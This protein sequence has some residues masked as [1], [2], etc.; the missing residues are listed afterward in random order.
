MDILNF[1]KKKVEIQLDLDVERVFSQNLLQCQGEKRRE[2]QSS[3]R[4]KRTMPFL[5]AD[6]ATD[7]RTLTSQALNII[8]LIR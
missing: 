5:L 2:P 1:T 4:Y 3:S 7:K 8:V 6:Q